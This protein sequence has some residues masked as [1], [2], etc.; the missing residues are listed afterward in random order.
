MRHL[1]I[2]QLLPVYPLIKS[3]EECRLVMSHTTKRG[4]QI[5]H[6]TLLREECRLVMSH[7]TKRGVQI[8]HVTL[9]REEYRLVTHYYDYCIDN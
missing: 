6:V 1:L 3:R 8:S 5:S 2:S 4:V 7:T 9:L